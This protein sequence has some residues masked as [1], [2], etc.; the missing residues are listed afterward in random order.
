MRRELGLLLL[1]SCIVLLQGCSSVN[2]RSVKHYARLDYQGRWYQI[3]GWPGIHDPHFPGE[4]L[5]YPITGEA[6]T[7]EVVKK[8]IASPEGNVCV[9]STTFYR[10]T[11]LF[12]L[13]FLAGGRRDF[14][15][16][17]KWVE[18]AGGSSYVLVS[19]LHHVLQTNSRCSA[20]ATGSQGNS[21]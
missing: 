18:E 12:Y 2:T 11:F 1:V 19:R 15:T 20:Q 9:Y 16:I 4:V 3:G 21:C 6:G 14:L 7:Y 10:R 5:E 13:V 8:H 17:V